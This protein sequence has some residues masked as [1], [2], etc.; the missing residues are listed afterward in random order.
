[1]VE[2]IPNRATLQLQGRALSDGLR[3]IMML[4]RELRT[5]DFQITPEGAGVIEGLLFVQG[6]CLGDYVDQVDALAANSERLAGTAMAMVTVV[7]TSDEDCSALLQEARQA[8]HMLAGAR[9]LQEAQEIGARIHSA[10][11]EAHRIL[12]PPPAADNVVPFARV[13]PLPLSTGGDAA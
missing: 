13:A 3:N 8:S 7:E 11:A 10:L 6:T 4:M 5:G 1:M 12:A 9:S 2:L